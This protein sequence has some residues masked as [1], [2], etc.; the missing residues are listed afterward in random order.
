MVRV[1]VFDRDGK[2]VGPLESPKLVLS[3]KEWKGRLTPEQYEVLPS[4]GTERPFTG[5]PQPL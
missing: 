3:I 2:L 1:R 5:K 4:K